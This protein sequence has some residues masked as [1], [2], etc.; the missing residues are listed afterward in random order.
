MVAVLAFAVLAGIFGLLL[1]LQPEK[2]GNFAVILLGISLLADG[3]LGFC[4]ALC[5]VKIIRNQKP[6]NPDTITIEIGK[7]D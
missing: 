1:I 4:V 3:L 2:Y 5:A 7:D 6:D